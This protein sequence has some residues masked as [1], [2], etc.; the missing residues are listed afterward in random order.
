[1][2]L[3]ELKLNPNFA[4]FPHS[5]R[6]LRENL[7]HAQGQTRREEENRHQVPHAQSCLQ[8]VLRLQHPARQD[9]RHD[10]RRLGPGQ[11]PALKERYD[12]RDPP[13]GADVAGRNEPLERDDE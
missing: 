7:A 1:M 6:S 5:F 10:L 3:Q 8:R 2:V 12:R 4:H 9:T 13:R 11:G